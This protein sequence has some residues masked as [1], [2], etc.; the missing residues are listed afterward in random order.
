MPTVVTFILQSK[1]SSILLWKD[2]RQP[3]THECTDL[4]SSKE[5]C[6]LSQ[7]ILPRN[8]SGNADSN[9]PFCYRFPTLKV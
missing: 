2:V 5:I 1:E 4:R 3:L 8:A 6:I 9:F 7:A